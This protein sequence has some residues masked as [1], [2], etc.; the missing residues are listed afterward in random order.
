MDCGITA[1]TRPRGRAER[2]L[3]VVITDHHRPG[4]TLPDCP[5]VAPH[6]RGDYPRLDLCGTGVAWK[7]GEALVA[8]AGADA[9]ILERELDLVALATVADIVPL[10]R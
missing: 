10:R 7:L 2:G 1:S 4:D 5:V 9:A 6:G 8:R 3:G